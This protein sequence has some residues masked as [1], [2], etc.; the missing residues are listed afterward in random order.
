MWKTGGF[1]AILLSIFSQSAWKTKHGHFVTQ[2][3]SAWLISAD[4]TWKIAMKSV[5][6][7]LSHGALQWS[8]P[9]LPSCPLS[10]PETNVSFTLLQAHTALGVPLH[11]V[12]VTEGNLSE[13]L[14]LFVKARGGPTEEVSGSANSSLTQMKADYT[15][16][17]PYFTY[18]FSQ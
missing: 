9:T 1:R 7:P 12:E 13:I 5:H 14:R 6:T 2:K 11:K 16:N 8:F 3:E 15:T 4:S 18:T 17:S 10:T